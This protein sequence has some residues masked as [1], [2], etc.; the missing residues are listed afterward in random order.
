MVASET[1]DV[2]DADCRRVSLGRGGLDDGTAVRVD[3]VDRDEEEEAGEGERGGD[4]GAREG[5][6]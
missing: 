4:I 6:G 2:E 5:G 3:V 1:A